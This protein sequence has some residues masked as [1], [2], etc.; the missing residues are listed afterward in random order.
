MPPEDYAGIPLTRL[1]IE[2]VDW[3]YR[4]EHIRTRSKRKGPKEFD[5]EPEWA[6]EA[7]LDPDRIFR[8]TGG[9]SIEVIGLSPSAP[10][11]REGETGRLLKVSI[12]PK[13]LEEG[14]WWR[15]SASEANET[16]RRRYREVTR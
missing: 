12:V 4:G 3:T 10:P 15:A 14:E 9:M 6:T 16:D 1:R 8:T 7:A 5:V 2:A 13:R 11:R